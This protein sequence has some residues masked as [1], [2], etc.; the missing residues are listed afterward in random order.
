[1]QERKSAEICTEYFELP[2]ARGTGYLIAIHPLTLQYFPVRSR[3]LI[4]ATCESDEVPADVLPICARQVLLDLRSLFNI[5][6]RASIA[7]DAG[8]PPS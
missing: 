1:M 7:M 6:R 8:I 5:H 4:S 3:F 2:D